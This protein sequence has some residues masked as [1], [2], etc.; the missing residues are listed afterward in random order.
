MRWV[1]ASLCLVACLIVQA[2]AYST[3]S[4]TTG[5]LGDDVQR[6]LVPPD[7]HAIVAP[8]TVG[9]D[10]DKVNTTEETAY[11]EQFTHPA[12]AEYRLRITQP[13]LCDPTVKQ[14][15][16]YL[17]ISETRHLFFWFFEARQDPQNAPFMLWL[18]GG[19]GCSSTTGLFFEMGPCTVFE[20]GRTERNPYSWNNVAN[21]LFLDQPIGTGF[22]YSTD[23]SKV[24]TLA[25]LAVDVY[26]F[27]QLFV[28]RFPQLGSKSLHLAAESW[29]GHY[30]PNIASYVH[31]MNK[32]MV[33]AP[34]PGQKHINLAS[35]I[36]AN[37]L[38][39]PAIQF[40]SIPEYMCGGAPYPPFEEGS[41][42]CRA[43]KFEA[44]ICK[45]MIENCYRY[46]FKTTC[47]PATAYCWSRMLT[48]MAN[49]GRNPYDL[50]LPCA[51]PDSGTCYTEF[52]GLAVWMNNHRHALGADDEAGAFVH[53]NMTT[54]RG[55][56]LQGQAMQNSAALL[57]ALVKAGIRLLVFAGDTDGVCNYIGV[58][59][60]MLRLEHVF[61]DEFV[62][63][64][65]SQFVA[66]DSGE[67]GGKV[68]KAGGSG[69]GNVTFVQ[70]YEGGH[71]APHDQ[72]E[73]TLDM[74]TRWVKDIPFDLID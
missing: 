24:D 47:D 37:G 12:F 57:P 10:S 74:I 71:M 4:R 56:Y 36:I 65:V 1:K 15:S 13:K 40:E 58:E 34:L 63:A 17:D 6:V 29:G 21:L 30:G 52:R 8:V 55:F 60:W 28:G 19:P 48:P 54:N 23:G 70:I 32:R 42:E 53:C 35:L 39:D 59:R 49:T 25:D 26:A 45:K 43:M 18:N 16:G 27:L 69:S 3:L 50:R 64:P 73:S 38:T 9:C 68:R 20:D 51:D 44:P 62:N 22:S 2:E 66:K 67:I 7:S 72:P 31:K 11:S 46:P 5:A 33:Y 61:H 41:A 14:Y